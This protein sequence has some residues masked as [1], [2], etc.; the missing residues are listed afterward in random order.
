MRTKRTKIAPTC[1]SC[2]FYVPAE[3][4]IAGLESGACHRFPPV[5]VHDG[6]V[7]DGAGAVDHSWRFPR[8]TPDEHCGEYKRRVR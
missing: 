8:V 6:N 5:A 4:Q 1:S 2:R 3:V 7:F